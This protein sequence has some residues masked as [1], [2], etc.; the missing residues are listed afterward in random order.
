MRR[1]ALGLLLSVAACSTQQTQPLPT[2]EVAQSVAVAAD[3][4]GV[5]RELM[6][7]IAV[8]EGGLALQKIRMPDPDDHVPVAGVL[9][10][11]HGAFNSL[12]RGA[13]LM[14][15]DELTLRADTDLGTEAGARVLAELGAQTGARG[16]DL[17]SW[18]AALEQLS[19]MADQASRARYAEDV[20]TIL[21]AGGPF[22]ARNGETIT[23]AAHPELTVAPEGP[24][25][26]AATGTPDFPGAIWF[27]TSCSGKC[28]TTR[29]AGTAVVD[30]IIIHDTEGGWA[31]SVSTLQNDAGKSVHYIVDA[32]GSRVGQ[33]VPETYTAWHAG[34]Y[35]VNQRSVGIEH[36][37]MAADPNGYSDGL[38]EK[39]AALVKN[40]RSRWTV[41]LD[42]D[43]I[44]GHY[45]V[46]DGDNIAESAPRCS[47]TLDACE[48]SANYGGASNHRDPGYHWD[49]CQYMERLG[50]S[51]D[52]NDAYSLWNCTTD[53][54]E[55]VRCTSGKVEIDHCTAGCVSQPIGT[56]DVC[57]H[58]APTGGGGSGGGGGGDTGGG[59]A[60]GGGDTGGGGAGGGGDTGGNAD[61]PGNPAPAPMAHGGCSMGVAGGADVDG[62]WL[63]LLLLAAAVTSASRARSKRL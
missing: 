26:E 27:S 45:Q 30:L 2:G 43:H 5:P 12:A 62:A 60:G 33:F 3:H 4:N 34:N 35:Y 25:V 31:A 9:E 16:D 17:A 57:N 56:N 8:V 7:A 37:G 36:V 48:T 47:D 50:G 53:K 1:I 13:A 55:A 11:R 15:V 52:C 6:L 19:G 63:M 40:I 22:P 39:S 10:L 23:I 24:L 54:T 20:F 58:T 38:Y 59:G 41:P 61:N 49:W 18:R 42:R 14:G 51:C 21:R 46:A 28:D 32:D 29:T 44:Y